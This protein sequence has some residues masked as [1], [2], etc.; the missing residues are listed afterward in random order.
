MAIIEN[1]GR[2][3][4]DFGA[5]RHLPE[6]CESLDI[7]RPLLASDRNLEKLGLVDRVR[8]ALK[9]EIDHAEYLDL[10]EHPMIAGVEAS[11]ERFREEQ[12]DGFLALGGGSIID[13]C[14]AATILVN[15]PPPLQQYAGRPDRVTGQ[16]APIIAIPTTA[17]TG[18]EM[19]RGGGIHPAHGERE[20]GVGGP[21]SQP[22]IAICDPDLT[23]G[24]PPHLTAGTGMD[25]IGHCIEGLFS[26]NINPP[27]E[28]IALDGIQRAVA[29]IERAYKNGTDREARWQMMMAAVQGGMAISKG[30][31]LAHSLSITFSDS[32]LHHGV[33]VTLCL[34]TVIRYVDGHVGD[35]MERLARAFNITDS[36]AVAEAVSDLSHRVELPP[37]IRSMGYDR[38]D[39]DDMAHSVLE[40]WFTK[41]SPRSPTLAEC[42]ELVSACL[43]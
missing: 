16:T 34:P 25:A 11:A 40:C 17:G 2:I 13:N 19:T 21:K 5:I 12:C 42:R 33:L 10:P 28:A 41:T 43:S 3:F 18:A 1:F 31:G 8:S 32:D 39:I 20:I 7:K 6:A 24:L 4:F 26:P 22:K 23:M 14:K 27:V 37:S 9:G 38:T 29:H 35:K 15:H 30:L 36:T